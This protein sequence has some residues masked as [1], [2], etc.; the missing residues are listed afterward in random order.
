MRGYKYQDNV[1][2]FQEEPI[3]QKYP[4]FLNLQELKPYKEKLKDKTANQIILGCIKK[5]GGPAITVTDLEFTK[6]SL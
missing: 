1:I 3:N 2:R 5:E 4:I 6:I